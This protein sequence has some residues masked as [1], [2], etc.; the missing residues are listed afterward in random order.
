MWF[1]DKDLE[2]PL[3]SLP[4]PIIIDTA[5]KKE[6]Q[7]LIRPSLLGVSVCMPDLNRLQLGE[8][9]WFIYNMW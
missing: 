2:T 9:K 4:D 5:P 3:L 8:V 6:T 7:A 1:A